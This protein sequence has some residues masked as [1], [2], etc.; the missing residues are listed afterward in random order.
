MRPGPVRL[1]EYG[2]RA[3]KPLK[4]QVLCGPDLDTR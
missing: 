4:A 2:R 1:P 3:R